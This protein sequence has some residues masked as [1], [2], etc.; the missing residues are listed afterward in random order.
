MLACDSTDSI[1]RNSLK[2]KMEEQPMDIRFVSIEF[3][4]QKLMKL[5]TQFNQLGMLHFI[6]NEQFPSILNTCS[7]K[8]GRFVLHVPD[9]ESLN[10]INSH[11]PEQLVLQSIQVEFANQVHDLKIEGTHKW[12]MTGQIA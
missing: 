6:Y 8:E 4:S 5:I 1:I 11:T 12:H 2:L 7:Y 3:T 10:L 9:Y